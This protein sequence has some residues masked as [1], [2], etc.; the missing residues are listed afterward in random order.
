MSSAGNLVGNFTKEQV[1]KCGKKLLCLSVFFFLSKNRGNKDDTKS[2]MASYKTKFSLIF[3]RHKLFPMKVSVFLPAKE[4]TNS[5]SVYLCHIHGC[6]QGD[7]LRFLTLML[8]ISF[9]S[10]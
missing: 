2:G 4:D 5:L 8:Q 6:H 10:L 7:Y 9:F 3:H 1:K